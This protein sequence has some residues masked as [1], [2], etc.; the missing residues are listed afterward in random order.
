MVRKLLGSLL[1]V[2]AELASAASLAS[3]SQRFA[4]SHSVG[5]PIVVEG[6][7]RLHAQSSALLEQARGLADR[8]PA[9][10]AGREAV[11]LTLRKGQKQC[12]RVWR[13]PTR[14]VWTDEDG[15]VRRAVL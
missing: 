10:A 9:E 12:A 8:P 1:T 11:A 13:H 14:D 4:E 15:R 7:T 5:F 6:L 3:R 2:S